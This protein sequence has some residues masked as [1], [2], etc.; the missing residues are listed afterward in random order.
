LIEFAFVA[1]H[2][3]KIARPIRSLNGVVAKLSKLDQYRGVLLTF[4]QLLMHLPVVLFLL[5][6]LAYT[7]EYHPPVIPR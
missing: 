5:W 1:F 6:A 7:L 2:K 4:L 3:P